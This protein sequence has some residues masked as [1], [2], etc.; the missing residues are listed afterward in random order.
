MLPMARSAG[1]RTDISPHDSNPTRVGTTPTKYDMTYKQRMRATDYQ[2]RKQG[3]MSSPSPQHSFITWL[4]ADKTALCF[5][6][7]DA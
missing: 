2:T 7:K 6:S 1:V 3:N 4:T 5:Y